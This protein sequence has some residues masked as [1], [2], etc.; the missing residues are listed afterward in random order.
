MREEGYV[1]GRNPTILSTC[2][3][4]LCAPDAP[5]AIAS[6]AH[7][8]IDCW[9]AR[10]ACLPKS[11]A[12]FWASVASVVSSCLLSTEMLFASYLFESAAP[13]EDEVCVRLGHGS[14][15]GEGEAP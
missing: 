9:L 3:V 7:F 15:S 13:E 14:V 10:C 8:L 12:F 6:V 4:H 11:F 2:F 1:F 5:V